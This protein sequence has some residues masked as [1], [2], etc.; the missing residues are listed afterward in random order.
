MSL[1]CTP[2]HPVLGAQAHGIDL[3]QPL[4]AQ[5]VSAINAAMN[6]YAVLVFRAE[7][8]R[9]PLGWLEPITCN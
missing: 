2:L 5:Q 4:S 6:Q 1:T 8:S 3:T 9:P 7:M